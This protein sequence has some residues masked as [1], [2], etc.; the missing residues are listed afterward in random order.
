MIGNRAWTTGKIDNLA[1]TTGKIANNAVDG[2][3]LRDSA[4]TSVIGK[5]GAGVG[6]PADI[7]AGVNDRVL[8]QAGGALAFQQV[9]TGMVTDEAVTYAKLEHSFGWSVIGKTTTGAGDPADIVAGNDMVLAK[10]GVGN[11]IFQKI[12]PAMVTNRLRRF[13]VQVAG[14]RDSTAAGDLIHANVQGLT[15]LDSNNS[16]GYGQF[17]IPSDYISGMTI[18]AVVNPQANGNI[19]SKNLADYGQC[20]EAYATHSNSIGLAAV[21]VTQLERECIQSIALTNAAIWDIVSL[22]FQRDA[23]NASDTINNTV[24]FSG[25]IIE[26]TADS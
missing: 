5:A 4:A 23:S 22:T 24:Y 14:G 26:Y 9:T 18:E 19:Y 12:V 25:W 10:L 7:V 3:K 17:I 15:F 20:G 6:D 8:A 16:Y 21:A 2:T 11:V 13:F 1:V